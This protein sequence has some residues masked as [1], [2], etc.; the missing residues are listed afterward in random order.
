[1]IEIINLNFITESLQLIVILYLISQG[2]KQ[3]KVLNKLIALN[4]EIMKC[5][6]FDKNTQDNKNKK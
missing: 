5:I 2:I 1:M 6:T 4:I 3:R